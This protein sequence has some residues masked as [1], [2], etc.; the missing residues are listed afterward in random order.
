MIILAIECATKAASV[1]LLSDEVT[2]GEIYL[3]AGRH[4]AETVLQSLDALLQLAGKK[5]RDV[6]LLACTTGPGSFTGVRIGIATAKGLAL[7]AGKPIIAVSTLEALAMNLSFS[8]RLIAPLLDARKN[9][10]YAGLYRI[11]EDG[12]PG[13]LA[14]DYL[15]DMDAALQRIPKENVDFIGDGALKHRQA[16]LECNPAAGFFDAWKFNEPLASS[17]GLAALGRCRQGCKEDDPYSLLPTYLRL[18]EAEQKMGL[19]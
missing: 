15:G 17:V 12:L 5:I 11:K 8:A 2:A 16:I 9:Q 1:A 3:G 13:A 18:S 7:A 4:H 6:D 19:D 10:V 14:D